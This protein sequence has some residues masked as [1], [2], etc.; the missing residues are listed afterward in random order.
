MPRERVPVALAAV[1]NGTPAQ[2]EI[3]AA[4]M[5]LLS[6]DP[7]VRTRRQATR[8]L[9]HIVDQTITHVIARNDMY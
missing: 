7:R 5:L 2:I 6:S 3:C 9:S 8:C 1:V 4:G